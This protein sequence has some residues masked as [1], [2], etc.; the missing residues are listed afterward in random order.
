MLHTR[1]PS[2]SVTSPSTRG[3]ARAIALALAVGILA[4]VLAAC[5]GAQARKA[6]HFEKGK[7]YLAAGNYEKARVEF[8]NVL[9]IAPTDPEARFDMGLVDEKLSKIREA[10]GFY[11]ATIEVSPTHVEARSHLA[12]LYVLSGAPDRAM[13]VL[14]PAID[15]H[16]DDAELLAIRA[17]IHAQ[18]KEETE[19]IADAERAV[20][21]D[22]KN[23]D[24][25]STLA[26]LYSSNK[27]LPRAQKLLEDGIANIPNTTDLRLVLAHIYVSE[28]HLDEAEQTLIK[29]TKIRPTDQSDRI[30]LA[31]FYAWQNK[32]DAAE[33][34][35]RDAIAE[36]PQGRDLKLQLIQLIAS[37]RS[38]AAAEKELKAMIAADPKDVEMKFALAKFYQ[39]TRQPGLA[40]GIY[41]EV[42]SSDKLE[43][44]GLAARDR[45]AA[46]RAQ[47]ND[48]AGAGTLISEVLAKSPRDDEALILRGQ[49]E[50]AKKD[51]KAAIA[52]LRAVLRD[53]PNAVPVLRTLASA[54]LANGEP[55][56]AE[57]TMRR[58][59]EV[60][61]KDVNTRLDLA[62]LLTQL[63]KPDQA[64]PLLADV[65]KEQP[66]NVRALDMQFRV[67]VGTNDLQTAKTAA[68][69]LVATQPKMA[70]GY[71]FEGMLAEQDK[72]TDDAL[73]LY[74]QAVDL[75]P[76][77]REPLDAQIRLLVAQKRIPD[78]LKRLDDVTA[79]APKSPLALN[80]KGD[81]LAAQG[82][83][84][85]AKEAY[86]L[87]L[88]R[89]PKWWVPYR[90]LAA[91]QFAA[92]DPD[93]AVATL[94][95]G[96]AT[97][98]QPEF[99]GMEI[100]TYYERSGKIDDAIRE[101][102]DVLHRNPQTDFAANNLAMLLV[103]NRSDSAS[104][105]RAKAVSSR[106][107]Q[108]NNLSFLDTYGWVL[109]K[110]GEANASVPVLEQVVAKAPSAAEARYHLG[111]ALAKAGNDVEARDNL[112]RAVDSGAKF[113]G[114]EEARAALQ[115]LGRAPTDAAPKS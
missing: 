72:K 83:P 47:Q 115:K 57:E 18:K 33:K 28:N 84:A 77:T 6:K 107:A 90:G 55:A 27:D 13:E 48:L 52:D 49:I 26:G 11:Q 97:V 111:M 59:L 50:L 38:A 15:S 54:H 70:I 14:K 71:L 87:A 99:L 110:H 20:K 36:I 79:L 44:T 76:D 114:L 61:P 7:T 40:E 92:K 93:A 43:P 80:L 113:S 39:D 8:Q 62:L 100:A 51:P 2:F 5:G 10:A 9:Q 69:A 89:T 78:A 56:I 63:N 64:K 86:E 42:I 3:A 53:Q 12:R 60:N 73:R 45:L 96:Q 65:V 34:T 29:I 30:R 74:A 22:P 112:T 82:R 23:E 81:L 17:A 91:L 88:A 16:P 37:R 108:S 106:F 4:L 35:L 41:K 67:G 101:Y 98:E 19:A 102:E 46:L 105:D 85:E 75:A 58:A 32:I 109:Y 66:G 68:Q 103:N 94:R 104:L 24:A 95:T 31:Q 25:I 1:T 21:L